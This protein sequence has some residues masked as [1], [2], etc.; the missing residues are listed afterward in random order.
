MPTPITCTSCIIGFILLLMITIG[1]IYRLKINKE[2]RKLIK[3]ND[4]NE[5]DWGIDTD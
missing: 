4:D 1:V 5:I 2:K 3:V